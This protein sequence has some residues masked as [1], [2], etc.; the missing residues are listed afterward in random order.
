M[1]FHSIFW[2]YFE[3]REAVERERERERESSNRNE[4][5]GVGDGFIREA[6]ESRRGNLRESVQSKG[7]SHRE[8]RCTKKDTSP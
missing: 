6:R 3:S 1:S 2:V 8:D 7:E 5:D 4:H